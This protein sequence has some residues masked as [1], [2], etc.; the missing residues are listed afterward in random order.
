LSSHLL[1]LV[2][3]LCTRLLVVRQ[4]RAVAYGTI[5][6]IVAERPTLAGLP[7]EELFVALTEGDPPENA[8]LRG[9]PV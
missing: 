7:L 2:E 8:A 5:D 4:G 1:H 3:Q 6:E 9:T